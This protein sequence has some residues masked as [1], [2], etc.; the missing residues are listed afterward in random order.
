M[1]YL[2]LGKHAYKNPCLS[3]MF[4]RECLKD[5]DLVKNIVDQIASKKT[6]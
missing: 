5:S 2:E 4:D 6:K 1:I 3:A